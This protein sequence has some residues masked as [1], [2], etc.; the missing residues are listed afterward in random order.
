VQ[1]G[2][3]LEDMNQLI[4]PIFGINFI[5]KINIMIENSYQKL[6][7]SKLLYNQAEQLLLKEL[8]LLD[9]EPSKEKISIKSFSESFGDSGRLDS[10]Y[11]QP[12][13]DEII[14]KIKSYKGG[15]KSIR[16]V[17]TDDIRSGTTPK[18]IIKKYIP[19]SNYFLRTEAFNNDLTLTYNSLYSMD[20]NTFN[21]YNSIAVKQFDILV[22]MTGTIGSVAIITED[23]NAIINQNIVK[24][25]VN[26]ELINY[27]I[28]ALYMSTTG[29]V[30]LTKEQ[31]GNVQPYVNV[32][33]FSNLIVPL[34]DQSIQT[35]IEEKIKE[36]FRLK[37]ES[38]Q[39]LEV[40]KRAVE[41]AIEEGEEVAIK[42]M[43]MN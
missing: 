25:S 34:I 24:L 42:A 9:F 4:I 6:E 29:K 35:Q 32:P 20:D 17:L 28:L 3:L 19:N 22:S 38:K 5:T 43:P 39:L 12:K 10:E 16:E 36:S 18:S 37:E 13:Y 1:Q 14:A 40:A 21:K 33:N 11:Y 41:V 7:D 30:L 15:Y 2:L 31:T 27:N 26:N 23:I 8:D